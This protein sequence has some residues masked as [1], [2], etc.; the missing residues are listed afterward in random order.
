LVDSLAPHT[1]FRAAGAMRDF[2]A[3][4][5]VV[6]WWTPFFGPCDATIARAVRRGGT[7]VVFLCHNVLPHERS[8]LDSALS[9]I[10]LG[11]ADGFVAQNQ[12]DF[13]I[14]A[15]LYPRRPRTLTPL[16]AHTFFTRG[17]VDRDTARA[18]LGV[19]GPVVLFFGLVRAYK[20]LDVLL[21][22]VALARRRVPVT[23]VVAGEFYQDRAPYDALVAELGL[24]DAVR[25]HDRYLPNEEVEAFFRAADLVVMPYTSGTQ[26]GPAQ[27]ALSFERPIVVTRVGA[28]PDLVR[29]GQ[30]GYVVPPGD[31]EA[32]AAVLVE[33]FTTDAARRMAPAL[34]GA[35]ADIPWSTMAAAVHRVGARLGVPTPSES[36]A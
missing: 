32:L 28:L 35:G 12:R 10:G 8:R 3:R 25:I 2:G 29:E 15:R 14:L 31:A 24:R 16:P 13:D 34:A 6:P 7:R 17:A 18:A 33:F 20:G 30:T 5:L 4:L 22:S 11:A 23:L 19:T 1:W 36:S 27:V 9:H 26:S 21:R